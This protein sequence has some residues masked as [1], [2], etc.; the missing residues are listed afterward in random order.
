MLLAPLAASVA[1]EKEPSPLRSADRLSPELGIKTV[2]VAPG[3]MIIATASEATATRKPMIHMWDLRTR[4]RKLEIQLDE[5]ATCLAFSP[6]GGLLA[7]GHRRS[8][9][10]NEAG[11]LRVWSV[12][13]GKAASALAFSSPVQQLAFSPSQN[14]CGALDAEGVVHLLDAK[15][16]K[17]QGRIQGSSARGDQG[18]A[19]ISCF[20]FSARD[21]TLATGSDEMV[22]VWDF[23]AFQPLYALRKPLEV[24]PNTYYP[25]VATSVTFSPDGLNLAV[26]TKLL[27][28]QIWNLRSRMLEQEFSALPADDPQVSYSKDGKLLAVA[29]RRGHICVWQLN[30]IKEVLAISQ[31]GCAPALFLPD[32]SGLVAAESLSRSP[33]MPRGVMVW[34]FK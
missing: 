12:T 20:A 23:W 7:S 30:P 32:D 28:I 19:R 6:D 25:A 9:R 1:R 8:E 14:R 10:G 5:E 16:W 18:S 4:L 24:K 22:Q 33:S 3:G 2:A 29:G 21:K 27:E 31:S 17:L 34:K 13:D 11:A 26:G 15:S